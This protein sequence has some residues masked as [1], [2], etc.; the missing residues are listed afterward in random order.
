MIEKR[1]PI[2]KK[3]IVGRSDKKFCSSKCKNF[4]HTSLNHVNEVATQKIDKILHRNRKILLT[5]LG[6]KEVQ[7]VISRIELDKMNFN[8]DYFTGNYVNAQGKT[9][10]Y[11]YDFAWMIFSTQ[12]ILIIRKK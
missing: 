6:K 2:C 10:N 3:N 1:C 4:F 7:K 8:F 5:L 12:D 9:Y 11:V